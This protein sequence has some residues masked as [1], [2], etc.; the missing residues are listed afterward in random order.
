MRSISI[1]RIFG[2]QTY[3]HPTWIIFVVALSLLACQHGVAYGLQT[4][5]GLLLI[6]LSV[7]VHEHAHVAVAKHYRI[8]TRNI[9]I[10]L[11]G[12]AAALES[13][14]FGRK[15]IFIAAAGPVCSLLL[16]LISLGIVAAGVNSQE[17]AFFGGINVLLGLF[18][19]LP[20][21]PLD[22]GRVIRSLLYLVTKNKLQATQTTLV[23]GWVTLL[24]FFVL[25]GFTLWICFLSIMIVLMGLAEYNYIKRTL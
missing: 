24:L 21:F 11:F 16:G 9:T 20:A 5:V 3:I 12:G 8:L 23:V 15:E 4:L 7:Y 14:P 2:V 6:Y 19:C 17:L 18:N 1:G 25:F 13:L 10:H 22:G